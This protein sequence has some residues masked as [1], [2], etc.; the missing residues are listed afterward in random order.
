[1]SEKIIGEG[2]TFDD[3][4]LVPRHSTVL[5]TDVDTSTRLTRKIELHIPIVS[6]AMDTVTESRLA[7]A[8]AQEGG[9]GIVHKNMEP[10]QQAREVAKVKR[11]E[12]GLIQDPFCLPPSET[13][14]AA[15]RLMKENN[16]SG[17]PVI[18]E[19]KLAG[20]LTSRDLR[21]HDDDSK[22]IEDVM[23]AKNLVTAREGTTLEQARKILNQSKVE[24][25]LIVD[26]D[27]NLR[28][29]ITMKDLNKVKEHPSACKDERGRL[30]VGAA[31]GARE[32]DRAAAL[33][34][35]DVDVLAVDTAHGHSRNVIDTVRELKKRHS[36]EVIAG[37]IATKEAARALIDAGADAIKVGIGPGSICTTRVI[38]GVGVPQI[39]AI[40]ETAK[41]AASSNTPVI[42]DGGI[43]HSGDITKAVAAGAATV[44]LGSLFA[45]CTESPGETIIHKGRSYKAYRGMGSHGAMVDGSKDR[46]G[47]EEIG[48]RSKLV[49]EGVEGMVPFKGPLADFVY[50]F[51]GG[52]RAGMGYC[53]A[54]GIDELR[55]E[56]QFLQ[57]TS[58]A[59]RESHP[60]DIVVLREAPNYSPE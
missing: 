16:I 33:V 44:M 55:R 23:T 36:V 40:L 38:A 28:G 20:I 1:M 12:A 17:I 41:E 9:L 25:L 56:A 34:E 35:C 27:F 48:D 58:A 60:H 39:T 6:S 46:Y 8:L 7:I 13:V 42:A 32:Y 3:V 59:L 4:L 11:F 19:R 22:S 43:R 49:P 54:A 26:A 10:E 14:G 18:R 53:G 45:G 57:V 47:Q 51:V 37:N 2:V 15:R 29:L 24:K 5:P 31:V 21:F 50:Q 30:R 52:L